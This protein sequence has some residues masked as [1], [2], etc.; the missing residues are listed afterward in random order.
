MT[1]T[2][3]LGLLFLLLGGLI[4]WWLVMLLG[5]KVAQVEDEQ[6]EKWVLFE[7]VGNWYTG[8]VESVERWLEIVAIYTRDT[9][10]PTTPLLA[11]RRRDNMDDEIPS[12]GFPIEFD[13]QRLGDWAAERGIKLPLGD[14]IAE[15]GM[16]LPLE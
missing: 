14:W 15:Q 1:S 12:F 13:G 7:F 3:E 2:Q 5:R 16:K 6:E 4:V 9:G 10:D 8:T 11:R